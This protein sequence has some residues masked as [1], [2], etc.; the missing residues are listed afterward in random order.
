MFRTPARKARLAPTAV[1]T[2]AVARA[3]VSPSAAREPAAPSARARSASRGDAPA[4]RARPTSAAAA[5]E[6]DDGRDR[7]AAGG[8]CPA[9]PSSPAIRRPSVAAGVA[10]V[11]GAR[12]AAAID[13]ANRRAEELRFVG[14]RRDDE[15]GRPGAARVEDP[16]PDR[17]GGSEI[18]APRRMDGDENAGTDA[19]ARARGRPSADS[20]RRGSRPGRRERRSGRRTRSAAPRH[21]RASPRGRGRRCREDSGAR[22][23]PRGTEPRRALPRA[24]PRARTPRPRR[25]TRA[26][27]PRAAAARRRPRRAPR[28]APAPRSRGRS[29][30]RRFRRSRGGRG[31]RREKREREIS[32]LGPLAPALVRSRY[33]RLLAGRFAA[34]RAACLRRVNV[35]SLRVREQ[36]PPDLLAVSSRSTRQVLTDPPPR[37]KRQAVGAGEDLGEPV[38]DEDDGGAGVGALPQGSE[39]RRRLVGGEDGRRLVEDEDV[40]VAGERARD[41]DALA[42][43]DGQ[44]VDAGVR[45]AELERRTPARAARHGRAATAADSKNGAAGSRNA[46]L[47]ATLAAPIRRSCCGTSASPARRASRAL[48]NDAGDPRAGSRPSRPR[49]AP[50]RS[51]RAW[52]SRRRSRRGGR[53]SRREERRDLLRKEPGSRRSASRCG[54]VRARPDDVGAVA[55]SRN[56]PLRQAPRRRA[57]LP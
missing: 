14:I 19:R 10:G 55:L 29:C 51:T 48:R 40:R 52:I 3:S 23:S 17:G 8:R 25:E 57:S 41:L 21:E 39:E 1:R 15:S 45:V 32:L 16:A 50:R 5:A 24:G 28:T 11:E 18:E 56:S 6:N 35:R 31:A 47:S 13:D 33:A 53:G 4:R 54:G 2:R 49:A 9:H 27:R 38:G 20:R 43:P 12:E 46:R 26:G 36:E 44:R 42:G 34:L 30:R 22:D 7:E 37:E